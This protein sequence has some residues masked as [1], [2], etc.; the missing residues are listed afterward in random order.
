MK[1]LIIILLFFFK[2]SLIDAQNGKPELFIQHITEKSLKS[3]INTLSSDSLRGRILGDIGLKKA[4]KYLINK[5]DE[6]NLVSLSTKNKYSQKID[7]VRYNYGKAEVNIGGINILWQT[8][9]C[10]KKVKDSVKTKI[11]YVGKATMFDLLG[12]KIENKALA[13]LGSS[14]NETYDRIKT[15]NETYNVKTFL[16]ILPTK[17]RKKG[18]QL[19]WSYYDNFSSILTQRFDL[20]YY[21]TIES[22]SI[23][24]EKY[25]DTHLHDLI[26][27]KKDIRLIFVPERYRDFSKGKEFY[28][29]NKSYKQLLKLHEQNQETKQNLYTDLP[30]LDLNYKVDYKCKL[31]TISTK[32][33]IGLI[34]GTNP[35]K[36]AIIISGHFDHLGFDAKNDI[37]KGAD[38]NASGTA[39]LIEL[40]KTFSI[41]AA[42]GFKPARTLIF[43]AFTAEEDGLIGS[44][45]YL[46]YPLHP[47]GKTYLNINIDMIGRET[48]DT[49]NINTLY[50]LHKRL[51]A[52][53]FVNSMSNFQRQYGILTLHKV[54]KKDKGWKYQGDHYPFYKKGIPIVFL[55]TGLHQDYHEISDTVDKI[56][57]N[58][59]KKITHLTFRS[60]W[61]VAGY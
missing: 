61:E 5:F 36:G 7:L 18:K 34:E 17:A 4:E 12:L 39:V 1:F 8:T 49:I 29:F 43:L 24:N 28:Y 52:K 13:I 42:S 46:K 25:K 57:F 54:D 15:L 20:D 44:E 10:S 16:I 26:A 47:I 48:I 9:Y 31:D 23:T 33:V 35:N 14:I 51:K 45:Y 37:F 22:F 27:C 50:V 60:I 40:A 38:D 19:D 55:H 58:K 32:N 53:E 11:L 41:A 59:L 2:L 56:E 6:F 3:H 30:C 21:Q